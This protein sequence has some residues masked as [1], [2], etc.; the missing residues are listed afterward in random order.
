MNNSEQPIIDDYDINPLITD[1]EKT[2]YEVVC[3]VFISFCIGL[4][5]IISNIINLIV[6]TKQGLDSTTNIGLFS[7][8]LADL[9]SSVTI[10][11]YCISFNPLLIHSDINF[12]PPE[13]QHLTAGTPHSAFAC[14]TNWITAYIAAERCLS[15]ASPLKVKQILT[16]RRTGFIIVLIYIGIT[17][18]VVPEYATAYLAPKFFPEFNKTLVGLA[19]IEGRY[20]L[21]GISLISYSILTFISFIA[22]ILFTAILVIRLKQKTSWRRLSTFDNVQSENMSRRDRAAIKMVIVIASLFIVNFSP[23]VA[24]FGAV[25]IVPEFNITGKYRNLFLVSAAF[26]FITDA[27]NASINIVSYYTMSTKYRQTFQQVFHRCFKR[28]SLVDKQQ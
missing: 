11:W 1:E 24:F 28:K 6:F 12:Y 23:T 22:V 9:L 21:G 26:A 13:V 17:M 5:G 10:E 15:I 7:L 4:C 16:P 19:F 2:I 25:F 14:I 20:N 27:L 18:P 3:L 8:A